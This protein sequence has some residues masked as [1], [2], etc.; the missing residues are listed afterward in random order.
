MG[1]Q[2][3]PGFIKCACC[4]Y[5]WTWRG[6]STCFQCGKEFEL[7]APR[8][9]RTETQ[10]VAA[11]PSTLTNKEKDG[12][13]HDWESWLRSRSSRKKAGAKAE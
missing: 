10:G 1:K 4:S 2:A 5:K 7:E 3:A 11:K 13:W 9:W 8:S 12:D 6:R